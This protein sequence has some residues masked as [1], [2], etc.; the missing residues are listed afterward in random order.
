MEAKTKSDILEHARK[1]FP[2]ECC[3]LIIVE[4]GKETYVPCNNVFSGNDSF[5][6]D[7]KDY[8]GAYARGSLLS[9]VHSHC[10]ARALPSQI[11]LVSCETT[12]LPWHI[13][14]I[15]NEEWVYFEPTNY[16]APLIGRQ[17]KYGV[18]DCLTVVVDWYREVRGISLNPH[19][20]RPDKW[21]EQGGNLF[22][23]K[24]EEDGFEKVTGPLVEGDVILMQLCAKV[25]NHIGVY[26]EPN[27]MLHHMGNR[28]STRDIYGGWYRKNCRCVVRYKAL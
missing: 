4:K 7:P 26:L 14:S 2:K 23:D 5:I 18:L 11:D 8:I 17:Y 15:P 1:E 22:M 9:V 16:K 21:W 19:L 24:F 27:L 10:N 25:V 20:D 3:G 6:I 13:V 28:L 12:K